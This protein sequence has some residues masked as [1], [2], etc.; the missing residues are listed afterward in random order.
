MFFEKPNFS[1]SFHYRILYGQ[2]VFLGAGGGSGSRGPSFGPS[3]WFHVSWFHVSW[4]R[5]LLSYGAK[6]LNTATFVQP[7]W[8]VQNLPDFLFLW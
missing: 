8:R 3:S 2:L 7:K 4:Q 6:P 5:F 1:Y